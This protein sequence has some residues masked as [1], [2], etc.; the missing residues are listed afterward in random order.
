MARY[1]SGYMARF[2]PAADRL[3]A[4]SIEQRP[5]LDI[6]RDYG[7]HRDVCFYVDPPYLGS[8][9]TTVRLYRH[10]MPAADEHTA[11]LDALLACRASVVLS[12]YA[13]PLYDT[14]L[15]GW[16]RHAFSVPDQRSNRRKEVVWTNRAAVADLLGIDRGGLVN[17]LWARRRVRSP[18][19]S[20]G[21]ASVGHE[22]RA[23]RAPNPIHSPP[24]VGFRASCGRLVKG[25]LDARPSQPFDEKP[26]SAR[27]ACAASTGLA[28]RRRTPQR[29]GLDAC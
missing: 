17:A 10:E 23:Q 6:I 29:G 1:L 19:L 15:Q 26:G 8:T 3:R 28:S 12:G 7:G 14:A 16:H 2:A 18:I 5:A 24:W 11:L 9:R 22:M 4:V 27:H 20:D 25:F 13:S 21:R